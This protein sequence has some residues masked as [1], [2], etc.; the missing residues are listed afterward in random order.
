MPKFDRLAA[1]LLAGCL[2]SCVGLPTSYAQSTVRNSPT[3][4]TTTTLSGRGLEGKN[5]TYYYQVTAKPG[6]MK[7]TLDLH[8]DD[9]NGNSITTEISVQTPDGNELDSISGF[10][11]QGE[12]SHTVKNIQFTSQTPIILVLNLTG[13]STAGYDYGIKIDGQWLERIQT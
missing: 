8:A 1:L 9:R 7:I 2:A 3:P 4:L 10:A 6:E 5:Q 13:G 11:T 12:S